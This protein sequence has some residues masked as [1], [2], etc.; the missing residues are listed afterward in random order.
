L[1]AVLEYEPFFVAAVAAAVAAVAAAAAAAAAVAR[2]VIRMA[3]IAEIVLGIVVTKRSGTGIA[4]PM[5]ATT[6]ETG[7]HSKV[8]VME[9]MMALSPGAQKLEKLAWTKIHL[10]KHSNDC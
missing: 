2:Q 6:L 5:A 7:T 10:Q 9:P 1:Q 3:V 4:N 8:Q